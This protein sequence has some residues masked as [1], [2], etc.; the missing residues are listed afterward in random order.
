MSVANQIQRT[1]D[2]SFKKE[3]YETYWAIDIHGTILVPSYDLNEENMTF[4]PYAKEALQKI[5]KRKDI[6]M[7][8]W[9]CSYPNEVKKYLD[10]FEKK[11]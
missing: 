10:F 9:T 2:V 3:W 6:V 11:L 5:S 1:F 7:I 8:L 4:Y